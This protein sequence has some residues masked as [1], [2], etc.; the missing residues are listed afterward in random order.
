MSILSIITATHNKRWKF[1]DEAA[2][3]VFSQILP[4]GWE[5]E[6]LIQVDGNGDAVHKTIENLNAKHDRILL[7]QNFAQLGP[8]G[9]RNLAL[10]RARGE[11]IRVFDSDDILLPGTLAKQI[12]IFKNQ[13]VHWSTYQPIEFAEDGTKTPDPARIGPGLLEP[14]IFS[15]VMKQ[16]GRCPVHCAGLMARTQTVRAFGGWLGLPVGEDV[17]LITAIS[18]LYHGYV[19]EDFGWYYRRHEG[20]MTAK[21]KIP[22]KSWFTMG[23]DVGA[24]RVAAMKQ[25]GWH[26]KI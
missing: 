21:N 8:G 14:G 10:A 9:T 17:P 20:Q 5:L 26:T 18:E 6:W 1:Y 4:E 13:D 22:T 23:E 25:L 7:E 11:L 2:K 19:M 16:L 3:S 24:Q 15:K 12:E